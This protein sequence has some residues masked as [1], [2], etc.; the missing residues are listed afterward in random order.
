MSLACIYCRE[1][2]PKDYSAECCDKN[3]KQQRSCGGES[4]SHGGLGRVVIAGHCEC[5]AFVGRIADTTR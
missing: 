3:R 1:P 4:C 5:G 2:Y